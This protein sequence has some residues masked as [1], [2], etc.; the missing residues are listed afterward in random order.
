MDEKFTKIITDFTN[1][2]LLTFPELKANIDKINSDLQKTYDH[3]IEMYPKIFFEIL[4]ENNS[5]FEKECFLLPEIDFTSIMKDNDKI[6][7]ISEKTKKTIWK[8]L[9]LILFSVLEKIN[10]NKS[11][12]ETSKI[13]E[14]IEENELHKK[15]AETMEEMKDLFMNPSSGSASDSIPDLSG[16]MPDLDPEKMKSHLDDLMNGKIGTLAK[17]IA[18]EA[19]NSIGDEKEFMET[20]M[21]NP[22][23]I[24]SLVKNI[25]GKL[26]EKIS[27]GQVKESELLEEA[28]QIM[29][30][31]QD[32]PGLKEMMAKMGLNGKMD[33]KAMANKMQQHMKGSKTKERLQKKRENKMNQREK[34]TKETKETQETQVPADIKQTSADTFVVKI[35]ESPQKSSKRKNKKK[36]KNKNEKVNDETNQTE[37]NK[38]NQN[39]ND[40]NEKMVEEK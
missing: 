22:Q 39:E 27:S 6:I 40:Q 8:Y 18:E 7:G 16:V 24:L 20:I 10:T 11:F 1:D 26:E 5:L 34:E 12:G 38:N 3:C 31:I 4:Y 14:G 15:I 29:D 36:N 9:Q 21:K 2:L 17:E 13:F 33:F 28:T 30:K 32:I 37:Q 23:K 19:K 35:G 25:G